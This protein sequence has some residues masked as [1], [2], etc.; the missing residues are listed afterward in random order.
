MSLA[1]W[2]V[3]G[4]DVVT[5]LYGLDAFPDGLDNGSSL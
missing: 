5:G 2:R 1:L 3:A 4:H